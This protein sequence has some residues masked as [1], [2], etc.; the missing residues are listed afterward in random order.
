VGIVKLQGPLSDEGKQRLHV[1]SM[2]LLF[3]R[4]SSR[5]KPLEDGSYFIGEVGKEK[6]SR[7]VNRDTP[8]SI[9]TGVKA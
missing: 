2:W 6:S 3:L 5:A 1:E 8:Y 9:S 4:T 7:G